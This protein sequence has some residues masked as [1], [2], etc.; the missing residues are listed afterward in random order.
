MQP[1]ALQFLP[2]A[3]KAVKTQML[4][5]IPVLAHLSIILSRKGRGGI[6]CPAD[7]KQLYFYFVLRVN[8]SYYNYSQTVIFV[9]QQV[10]L[11][12]PVYSFFRSQS[13][14]FKDVLFK[15]EIVMWQKN[16]GAGI[17]PDSGSTTSWP[18]SFRNAPYFLSCQME[19]TALP[20]LQN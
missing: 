19:I 8:S 1:F 10:N 20:A 6:R 16:I 14:G 5:S 17:R 2:V 9:I 7:P 13:K 18:C 15:R 11:I 12:R 3:V 4:S